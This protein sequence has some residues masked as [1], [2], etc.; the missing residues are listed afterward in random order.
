MFPLIVK[1]KFLYLIRKEKESYAEVAKIYSKNKSSIHEIVRKEKEIC[2]SFAVVPAKVI[3]Q[4]TV[5]IE[6]VQSTFSGEVAHGVS[7]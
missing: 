5:Q 2:A 3:I 4:I 6:V 7:H 1:I